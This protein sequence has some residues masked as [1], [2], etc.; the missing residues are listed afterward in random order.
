MSDTICIPRAALA[1]LSAKE[2]LLFL[3]LCSVAAW[4]A[5][6]VWGVTVETGQY[7]T[8]VRTLAEEMEWP[9]TTLFRT[10]GKLKDRGLITSAKVKVQGRKCANAVLLTLGTADGTANGTA[11]IKAN[12]QIN[13]EIEG[14][15]NSERNSE[16]NSGGTA[17]GTASGTANELSNSTLEVVSKQR[18]EQRVEH[19]QYIDT[20]ITPPP[21]ACA[22]AHEAQTAAETI[23]EE[24]RELLTNEMIAFQLRSKTGCAENTKFGLHIKEFSEQLALEG[25]TGARGM[26]LVMHYA[27]WL[28]IKF[29]YERKQNQQADRNEQARRHNDEV[30]AFCAGLMRGDIK[31]G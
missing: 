18:M 4:G 30:D 1:G 11:A 19:T 27:A 26:K 15:I 10:L 6:D 20:T 12:Q 13:S 14:R 22:C 17:S 7:L 28:N 9:Q 29:S 24:L 23:A 31:F 2:R 5:H 8:T 3:Y 21:C 25:K 16:W